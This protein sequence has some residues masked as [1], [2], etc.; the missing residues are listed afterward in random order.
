LFRKH[1]IET[2]IMSP[3]WAG[4]PASARSPATT[5]DRQRR[6][7]ALVNATL[8]GGDTVMIAA[9]S[10]A[11]E[12]HWC[13]RYK[14]PADLKGKDSAP[15]GGLSVPFGAD[16]DAQTLEYQ[17]GGSANSAA[18]L[19]AQHARLGTRRYRDLAR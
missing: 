1:G 4:T 14:T 11:A 16:D 12:S 18:R 7:R 17:P 13:A 10:T 15:L 9:A 2:E 19:I 8:R 3:A 5:P 6:R